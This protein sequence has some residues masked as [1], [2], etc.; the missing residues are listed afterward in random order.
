MCAGPLVAPRVLSIPPSA[1]PASPAASAPPPLNQLIISR[2][3]L[4]AI[5][6]SGSRLEWEKGHLRT[7]VSL[8]VVFSILKG[9]GIHARA[10]QP[11]GPAL[12]ALIPTH[13]LLQPGSR[14]SVPPTPDS[15]F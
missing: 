6:V 10:A 9:P 11:Y 7:S 1:A 5:L 12:A 3:A 8:F 2:A 4:S 13:A 14:C 15:L